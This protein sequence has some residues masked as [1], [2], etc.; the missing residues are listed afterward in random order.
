MTYTF[1]FG[2][3]S[4]GKS[5]QICWPALLQLHTSWGLLTLYCALYTDDYQLKMYVKRNSD[6]WDFNELATEHCGILKTEWMVYYNLIIAQ[7]CQSQLLKL[8]E[9][10]KFPGK[11]NL[12]LLYKRQRMKK[13]MWNFPEKSFSEIGIMHSM[14]KWVAN[15][16]W[17]NA[18]D[19][20]YE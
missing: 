6:V 9:I 15:S 10:M 20:T 3:I 5:V 14:L 11:K 13:K 4:L 8:F 16:Y 17:F 19:E 2:R 7:R 12:L 1:R 18:H